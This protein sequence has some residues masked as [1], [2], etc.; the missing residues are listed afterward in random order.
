[1]KDKLNEI[2]IHVLYVQLLFKKK[3]NIIQKTFILYLSV[4]SYL[5]YGMGGSNYL[6]SEKFML[7]IV[8]LFHY[9][10]LIK[11]KNLQNKN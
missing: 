3:L 10:H 9:I 4:F 2:E 1:M 7:M 5:V 6:E 8:A 11:K